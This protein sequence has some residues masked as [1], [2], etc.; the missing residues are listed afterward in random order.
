MTPANA[1]TGHPTAK[2]VA[3]AV[4]TLTGRG[5]IP[6]LLDLFTEDAVIEVAGAPGI[7]FVGRF[8]TPERRAFFFT[9]ALTQAKP[10]VMEVRELIAD[11]DHAV[12]LGYFDYLVHSTGRSYYGDFAL[13]LAVRDGR[14]ARWQMYEDSWCVAQAFPR[15]S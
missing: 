10:E 3:T 9:D 15:P 14:I 12:V 7:D 5:D 4:V 11:G 2:D 1:P 6:A 13:H 8:A